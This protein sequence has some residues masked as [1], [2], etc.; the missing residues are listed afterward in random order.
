MTNNKLMDDH[1]SSASLKIAIWVGVIA[2][3][4][5]IGYAAFLLFITRPIDAYTIANAGVFGD[6]FGV[7]T[8][9]F[10]AL[11]FAG[12]A[13][14]IASQRE[15]LKN[16]RIEAAIQRSES[17]INRKEIYKQGFE[18]TFFQMLKLHNQITM[19]IEKERRVHGAIRDFGGRLALKEMK[20]DLMRAFHRGN[21]DHQSSPQ[22]ISN[23]FESFY[24]DFG[25]Q[26][27]HYF[28]FLYNIFRFLDESA[29]EN[30]ELYIRLVRAQIS[31]QELYILYYN[32]LSK[33]GLKFQKYITEFK[34]M[35]NLDPRELFAIEHME[36]I[37]DCGFKI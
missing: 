12:V 17:E 8:S 1:F 31:N 34:L 28:R 2:V 32:A 16:Q 26:L 13:Y 9:L 20:L 35:D 21:I 22:Q 29:I 14:T 10:S 19:E 3:S 33:R 4:S 7:L 15:E 36:L 6:S 27:A 25:F 18:N 11:A 30:K 5:I 37:P 23:E 24:I